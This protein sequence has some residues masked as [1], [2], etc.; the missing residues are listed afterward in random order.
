MRIVL[1][2]S[3]YMQKQATIKTIDHF[4]GRIRESIQTKNEL[5]FSGDSE[6]CKFNTEIKYC[7]SPELLNKILSQFCFMQNVSNYTCMKNTWEKV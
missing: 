7:I 1:V 3:V 6:K 5:F 4:R 2:Y